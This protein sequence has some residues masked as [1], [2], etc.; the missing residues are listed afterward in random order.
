MPSPIALC[1]ASHYAYDMYS[2]ITDLLTK[3]LHE[4][5]LLDEKIAAVEY[6]QKLFED[7]PVPQ[8][9]EPDVVQQVALAAPP[10]RKSV[11][12]QREK[13]VAA[14]STGSRRDPESK[15]GR[16]R[17]AITA[18]RTHGRPGHIYVRDNGLVRV[19]GPG[20]TPN[21]FERLVGVYQSSVKSYEIAQD[22]QAMKIAKFRE[23][24]RVGASALGAGTY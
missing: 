19:C 6:I 16:M 3:L 2:P 17:E 14:K 8:R 20:Y 7:A 11:E 12:E 15:Q 4:R 21:D 18:L 5:T 13:Y 9:R 10:P 1:A 23:V 22:L 24:S